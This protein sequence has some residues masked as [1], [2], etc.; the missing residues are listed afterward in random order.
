MVLNKLTQVIFM[1]QRTAIP[2]KTKDNG[3]VA[4][5]L[6]ALPMPQPSAKIKL[7]REFQQTPAIRVLMVK[8]V[9]LQPVAF[10][11]QEQ[12]GVQS[13]GLHCLSQARQES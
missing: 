11:C 8:I 13:L 7:T 1:A 2:W 5:A 12:A 9:H 6:I 3:L 10:N 4:V